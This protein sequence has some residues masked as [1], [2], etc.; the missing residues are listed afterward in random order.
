MR[1]PARRGEDGSLMIALLAAIVVGGLVIALF[2]TSMASQKRVQDNR[3]YQHAI[4][5]AD[6]GLQQGMAK[7]TELDPS[8][9]TTSYLSSDSMDDTSLDGID[10]E[11]EAH[12]QSPY[13][14]AVR[15]SGH[16]DGVSRTV[17]ATV[18]RESIFFTA[19]FADREIL[20]RGANSASSYNANDPD[21]GWGAVGSN[22]MITMKGNA[23]ADLYMLM[24][25]GADC[26]GCEPEKLD[27]HPEPFDLEQIANQIREDKQA[28]CGG[29]YEPFDTGGAHVELQPGET[30]CF[31]KF[32]V[33]QHDTVEIPN[34]SA[35]EPITIYMEPGA[36]F[37]IEH[38]ASVNCNGST[39]SSCSSS[40]APEA[41][42]LQ[43]Y[44]VGTNVSIANHAEIV[45]AIA[46]P[47]ADCS[48]ANSN[49][50]ADI[51]GSLLCNDLANQGGWSF[52]YDERLM[53][54]GTGS[55]TVTNWREE[56][57]GTTSIPD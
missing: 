10:F 45:A 2:G 6:A 17:E 36:D 43:I 26:E 22:G 8:D 30:Y 33:R 50:Q 3:A 1:L 18:E 7:I 53:D 24:G 19:A 16:L 51:Y 52:F 49:A 12:R 47:E 4:N 42:S 11:W 55:F 20:F 23:H 34:A 48:A 14:W 38:H 21:S 5:G 28:A 44:T 41:A 37:T 39:W 15:A 32:V 25:P 9:L 40:Q 46:A 31:D 13:S 54:V 29:S 57:A 56:H 35:D 27:G